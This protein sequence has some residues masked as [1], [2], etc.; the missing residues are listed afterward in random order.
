M[1]KALG[2]NGRKSPVQT[3]MILLVE[4]GLV[5]LAFQVSHF[6]ILLAD[7]SARS[8]KFSLFL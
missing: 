1:V 7:M 6:Y 2:S 5:Y 3:I 4:S 8:S